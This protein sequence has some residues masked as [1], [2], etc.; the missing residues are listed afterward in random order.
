MRSQGF[1]NKQICKAL[2]IQSETTLI[3]Y[4]HEYAKGGIE[5]LCAIRFNKPKSKLQ[6][7]EKD[8]KLYFKENPPRSVTEAIEA[9]KRLTGIGRKKIFCPKIF[10]STWVAILKNGRSPG[11]SRYRETRRV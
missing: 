11:K 1:F 9:I 4:C 6:P 7:Y 5:A 8:L 3:S 10:A 2:G